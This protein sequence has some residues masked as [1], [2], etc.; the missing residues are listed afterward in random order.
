MAIARN[1]VASQPARAGL[2]AASATVASSFARGILRRNVVEQAIATGAN[3]AIMYEVGTTIH[4]SV[5]TLALVTSG[6]RGMR[7]RKASSTRVFAVDLALVGAG[8]SI[9]RFLKPHEVEHLSRSIART[10]GDFLVLGGVSGAV[11]SGVDAFASTA[12]RTDL[13]GRRS[14]LVDVAIGGTFAGVLLWMRHQRAVKYGLVD[15][16]RKAIDKSGKTAQVKAVVA[17][18]GAAGGLL[19]IVGVED[20]IAQGVEKLLST[21]VKR[22]D[23]ASPLLGHSVAMG[24]ISFGM[25][26]GF[27]VVKK[28]I[29]LKDDIVE[30]AYPKPPLNPNVTAGPRSVI[31]FDDIGKEGRRFVLMTLNAEEIVKV[32][33][34]QAQDPVR[35][36][37]G[38]DSAH[39]TEE[40]A[41]LCYDEMV[42]LGA[43]DKSIVCIASPT[44]VGYVSYT[45]TESLE[46]LARGDCAT[47]VPQYALV[48]SAL[49]LFDTKDGIALQRRVLE[50][51]RDHIASMPQQDRPRLVQFGESL[52]A[53]VA[54]DVCG[55]VGVPDFNQLGIEAGL[56]FGVPF[57][58]STWL[59]WWHDKDLTD[60]YGELVLATQ[61]SEFLDDLQVRQGAAKHYMV[62]H[63]DDPV[64]KFS[65][66]MVV[67]QPWW[68]GP[69]ATRP[70]K[71]PRETIWRP[72]TTFIL[73]LVDLV[74][75]MNSKIGTFERI[76]HD[77]RIDS[78]QGVSIAYDLECSPDMA[79]SIDAALKAREQDW[80]AKRLVAR[81]FSSARDS[82]TKTLSSWGVN[83]DQFAEL[84]D[85]EP[86]V[87][88]DINPEERRDPQQQFSFNLGSG[89]AG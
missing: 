65:Y 86:L 5:E 26:K 77:Y 37:A 64:N 61:P 13:V 56:Y 47:I 46:Y 11:V 31:S 84:N 82:V 88:A 79:Q 48:P 50:L 17:G 9:K 85:I 25:I 6:N 71:V 19:V 52:G 30:P 16:E 76:G 55:D 54:L 73:T 28:K 8:I 74:N 72:V 14:V 66:R 80:A 20:A 69:P 24:V 33:G 45:F 53:N 89:S 38:Y 35:I 58:S 75:G 21:K 60:P 42:S 41:Q 10:T 4:S 32:V 29:E 68:L 43:F 67:K 78:C 62:V 87:G 27:A 57:R 12:L 51:S 23:I 36:V 39:N 22:F 59:N 2:V 83:T 3:A 18:V 15:P 49:A 7:G 44:G 34:G 63:N 70:P 40:L 81:K 1:A